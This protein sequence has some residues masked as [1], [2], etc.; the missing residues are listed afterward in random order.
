MF[1][2]AE[3]RGVR[4][5]LESQQPISWRVVACKCNVMARVSWS[6]SCSRARS[7]LIGRNNVK[8]GLKT[9]K[10]TSR[11][12]ERHLYSCRTTPAHKQEIYSRARRTYTRTHTHE[13]PKINFPNA[14]SFTC[15]HKANE[16]I[17]YHLLRVTRAPSECDCGPVHT[18]NRI[19][20]CL[21][22]NSQSIILIN[23]KHD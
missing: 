16:P 18:V 9:T 6:G 4:V 17:R 3:A 2:Y 11:E 15:F 20:I 10:G 8:R 13:V 12:K 21:I 1:S 19:G 7:N 14:R 23:E 22:L 5:K